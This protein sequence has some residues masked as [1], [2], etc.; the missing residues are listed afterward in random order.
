MYTCFYVYMHTHVFIYIH[1]CVCMY[2]YVV[3]AYLHVSV[4][5]THLWSVYNCYGTLYEVLYNDDAHIDDSVQYTL[6]CIDV[7]SYIPKL[8]NPDA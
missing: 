4:P 2:T 3:C 8:G 1:T 7:W 6:A 5:A